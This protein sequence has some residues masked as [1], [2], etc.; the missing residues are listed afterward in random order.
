MNYSVSY[1]KSSG[2]FVVIMHVIYLSIHYLYNL[3]CKYIQMKI[4]R[5]LTTSTDMEKPNVCRD[6]LILLILIKKKEVK[7]VYQ[8]IINHNLIIIIIYS[9]N[10][11]IKP[12]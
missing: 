10:D 6:D 5:Q 4:I 12:Y 11:Y 2:I 3:H 8:A 1:Y 7:Q 9:I